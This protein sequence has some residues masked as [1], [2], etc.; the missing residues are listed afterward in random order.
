[1]KLNLSM[2][3]DPVFRPIE[4]VW[5]TIGDINLTTG[6]ISITGIKHTIGREGQ[7]KQTEDPVSSEDFHQKEEVERLEDFRLDTHRSLRLKPFGF[8]A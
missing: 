7:L 6:M 8:S 3:K 2:S 5:L 4:L 1:M